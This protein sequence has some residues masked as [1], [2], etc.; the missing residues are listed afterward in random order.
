MVGV[1]YFSREQIETIKRLD[2]LKA[3]CTECEPFCDWLLTSAAPC[4]PAEEQ[5]D[6]KGLATHVS[7]M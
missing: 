7:H 1:G 2:N 3:D 6:V 4:I 5:H